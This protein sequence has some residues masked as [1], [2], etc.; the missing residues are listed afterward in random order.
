MPVKAHAVKAL[1]FMS[2]ISKLRETT[3]NPEITK[4][5]EIQRRT[6]RNVGSS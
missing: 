6:G 3:L 2:R 4:L 1:K 5:S